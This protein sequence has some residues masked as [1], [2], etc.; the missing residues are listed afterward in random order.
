MTRFIGLLLFSVWSALVLAA[1]L[2]LIRPVLARRNEIQL[3]FRYRKASA[4]QVTIELFLVL[5]VVVP[6]VFALVGRPIS[7]LNLGLMHFFRLLAE[8]DKTSWSAMIGLTAFPTVVFFAFSTQHPRTGDPQ[9]R[10]H[11]PR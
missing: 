9:D 1:M 3:L 7:Q 5:T 10:C 2:F 11:P 8:G 6:V 4:A